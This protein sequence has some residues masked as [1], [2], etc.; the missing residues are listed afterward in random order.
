MTTELNRRRLLT[1]GA[2][3]AGA[4]TMA[5]LLSACGG[6]AHQK[7]GANTASGLKA[8]LPAYLP[9]TAL[10][11]DIPSVAGGPD[12]ATDPG[13]ASYPASPVAT[14]SGPPGRGGSYTAVTP[15]WGTVP[16][17]GNSFYQ[18]MDNALGVNLTIKP[19]DGNNYNT[20]VPTMTAARKLPDWVN[21]PAWWNPNFNTGELAGTQL[22]DLTPHLSGDNIKKYPNLAALPTGAWQAGVWGDK[23][24]GIPCFATGFPAPGAIFHRRDVLESRGITA[25][26]VKSAEDLMNLG[27]EL[28]DAK[29]GVWAFED[30]WTYFFTSFGAPRKWK[31][32]GGKLVHLFETQEFLEALDWHYRLATSGYMH[33]D[34]LA[35]DTNS[36]TRFYAGKS[37]ITGDGTGAW[38]LA[39]YQ[40]GIAADP[41]Y[42]RGAFNSFAAD[43]RSKPVL[44]M[45]APSSMISYLN[46]SLKPD[47][48]EELLAVANYL[49]APY[50]SAE[51]TLVNFGVE[52]THYNRVN[53]VPTFTDEGK[54]DVQVTTYNFLASSPAVISNPGGD[55]V[56][57]DYSAWQAAN[58]RTLAKPPFWA[59]N[60][61]MPQELA[62]AEAAQA[63]NDTIIDCYHGKKKVSDVQAAVST[64][65]SGQGDRLKRWMTENVLD[66]YGTGQ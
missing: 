8:A 51:Y 56:T 37:L 25:D 31:V 20:I 23:L 55:V 44:Y 26:Q 63:V 7:T 35:G 46:A 62:A 65:K 41:K 53:G 28:T 54:K 50:G 22:A 19:A 48:I 21:L 27:R 58:V 29:R 30:V 59:M 10:K 64:W 12:A 52:G 13:F 18:A 6:G 4:V 47:Q 36:S 33:P 45:G 43:G 42:R 14:V 40:S 57:K 24:Y 61:S 3:I 17:P 38:T 49:A 60:Y 11:P 39:D 5:P 1:A 9:S 32:D 2:S 34:A 66:K 15:L 16:Q